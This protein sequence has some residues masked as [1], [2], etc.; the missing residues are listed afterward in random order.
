MGFSR[1]F[2]S[3]TWFGFGCLKQVR[4]ILPMPIGINKVGCCLPEA[5]STNGVSAAVFSAV[6]TAISSRLGARAKLM[7]MKNNRISPFV[8]L[9]I[10]LALGWTKAAFAGPPL[11]P[12][13][14]YGNVLGGNE[15][16]LN[17]GVVVVAAIDGVEYAR[18]NLFSN[19]GQ[20]VYTLK[21]PADDPETEAVDGGRPGDTVNFSIDGQTFASAPWQGGSNTQVD[22]ALTSGVREASADTSGS[23]TWLPWLLLGLALF[24]VIAVW[25]L[26]VR[27]RVQ[28][29]AQTG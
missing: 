11:L 19:E 26:F 25:F 23:P 13:A 4:D 6:L 8:L 15:T 24:L 17:D 2:R 21:V 3:P 18:G 22:L 7:D 20:W 1:H 10:M 29:A 14:F 27:P 16:A 12:A 28:S 5:I 9:A